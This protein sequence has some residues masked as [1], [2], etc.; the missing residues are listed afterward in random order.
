MD[1]D[2]TKKRKLS[3]HA[4]E[5]I[6]LDVLHGLK[7]F[8]LDMQAEVSPAMATAEDMPSLSSGSLKG[9]LQSKE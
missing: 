3:D 6:M 8:S 2:P 5:L 1:N 7:E 9:A 4:L